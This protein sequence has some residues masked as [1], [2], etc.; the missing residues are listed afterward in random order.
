MKKKDP[1]SKARAALR[2]AI[3]RAC[4][5]RGEAQ[6]TSGYRCA[7]Q[8]YGN[9][10]EYGDVEEDQLRAKEMAQFRMCRRVEATA[11][12]AMR[13]YAKAVRDA[14]RTPTR[15]RKARP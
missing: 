5:A 13:A 14:A 6:W 1:E 15:H 8:N 11:E 7:Y 12:R 3:D 9:G 4:V 10:G 2:A